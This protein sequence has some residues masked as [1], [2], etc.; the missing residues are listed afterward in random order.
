MART[1]NDFVMLA[2]RY[3]ASPLTSGMSGRDVLRSRVVWCWDHSDSFDDVTSTEKEVAA[4]S[5]APIAVVKAVL[6]RANAFCSSGSL[7]S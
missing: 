7:R 6:M 1:V 3:R 5:G 2:I 4:N